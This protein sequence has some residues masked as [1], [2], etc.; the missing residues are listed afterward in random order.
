MKRRG[1]GPRSSGSIHC[2]ELLMQQ[3]CSQLNDSSSWPHLQWLAQ[4][5]MTWQ[6]L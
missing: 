4:P 1:C 5:T 3:P 2:N 6:I